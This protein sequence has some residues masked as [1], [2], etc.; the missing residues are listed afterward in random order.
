[1]PG[2]RTAHRRLGPLDRQELRRLRHDWE[3]T[4][5]EELISRHLAVRPADHGAWAELVRL[6]LQQ[7]REEEALAI[8]DRLIAAGTGGETP[9]AWRIACLDL[10]YRYDEA[11]EEA[12]RAG[13]LFPEARELPVALG[14]LH[15]SRYRDAEAAECLGRAATAGT[16]DA[17]AAAWELIALERLGRRADIQ[18]RALQAAAGHPDDPGLLALCA[19]VL[20]DAGCT[21]AERII[22]LADQALDLAPTHADA[23]AART[24]IL[25]L[26]ARWDEARESAEAAA[27]AR[28]YNVP[29]LAE[30]ADLAEAQG[31][32]ADAV[33]L[34]ERILARCEEVLARHPRCFDA[35]ASRSAVLLELERPEEAEDAARESA[36][37]CPDDPCRAGALAELLVKRDPEAA[38]AVCDRGL[39][40]VPDAHQLLGVRV[41]VLCEAARWDEAEAAARDLCARRPALATAWTRL[42]RLLFA[43]GRP[44]DALAAL[45]TA[46][47]Q[48]PL[49]AKALH[50][51]SLLLQCLERYEDAEET[52][53]R[54]MDADPYD[55][56]AIGRLADLLSAQ[57][58]DDEALEL[59]RRAAERRPYGLTQLVDLFDG[60]RYCD[61]DAEAQ[62]LIEDAL[63][64][65]PGS[66][67]LL[68]QPAYVFSDRKEYGAALAQAERALQADPKETQAHSVR[69]KSL[70][71][72]GR[73]QEADEAATRLVADQPRDEAALRAALRA[74]QNTGRHAQ[75]LDCADR[76]LALEPGNVH[77]LCERVDALCALGRW[78]EA[79]EAGR[80]ACAMW[81]TVSAVRL[82][83]AD[84][85]RGRGLAEEALGHTEA[86]LAR[87]PD[88]HGA[89]L[90][91]RRT[92]SDLRRWEEAETA[93]RD[94]VS[95]FPDSARCRLGLAE[96]LADVKRPEEAL[97][98]FLEA[99]RLAPDWDFARA[100]AADC[101]TGL[102]RWDEARALVRDGLRELPDAGVLHIQAGQ[103]AV[104]VGEYDEG[105]AALDE[106]VRVE[107]QYSWAHCRRI[108]VLNDLRRWEDADRAVRDALR[109]LP[110]DAGVHRQIALLHASRGEG[111]QRL[112]W[113]ERACTADPFEEE[114][115]LAR[116]TALRRLERWDEAAAAVRE[117]L[118]LHPDSVDLRVERAW[119][120]AQRNRDAEAL[121]CLDEALRLDPDDLWA[122]RSRAVVLRA[123]GRQEE[124]TRQARECLA[125]RPAWREAVSLLAV[126]LD[127]EHRFEEARVEWERAL[128]LAPY[129]TSPVV[130]LSGALRSLGCL[131]EAEE[132]VRAAWRRDPAELTLADELICVLVDLGRMEEAEGLARDLFAQARGAEERARC[133]GLLGWV[134]MGRERY[135]EAAVRYAEAQAVG[136]AADDARTV[137]ILRAWAL[138]RQGGEANEREADG[139][140]RAV[141][142]DA[143]GEEAGMAHAGRGM[144]AFRAGR[145]AEAE[146]HFRRAVAAAPY[147][148][149]RADLGAV[150]ASLARHDEARAELERAVELDPRSVHARIELGGVYLQQ[151][152][153]AG[154]PEEAA[155]DAARAAGEFRRAL[156]L[157]PGSARAALGLALALVKTSGAL[158]DAEDVLRAA[159]EHH[160][161]GAEGHQLRLALARLLVHSG[162]VTQRPLLYE[163]AVEEAA[164]AL[165]LRADD[166]EAS[167]VAGLAEQRLAADS[168]DVRLRALHRMRALAHFKRCRKLGGARQTEAGRALRVLEQE[169]AVARGGR[170]GSAVLVLVSVVVLAAV[171]GEFL[172]G[173]R[174]TPVMVSTLTPVFAGLIVL[175]FLLPL[176]IRVKLPGGLEAD[177]SASL[178]QIS[179]G[180]TG[181]VSPALLRFPTA[182][183]P[184]GQLPRM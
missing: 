128:R 62:A 156:S 154:L 34:R 129:D 148:A 1:M 166:P 31:R 53:R 9:H 172:W 12:E 58:K 176:L 95:R 114:S 29:L 104:A 13:R 15:L 91:H 143:S 8:C 51:R 127:A 131:D 163:D 18:E 3:F 158:G 41:D 167:F 118:R 28:P 139:L 86:V 117:A 105:V 87:S 108:A 6:R 140:C 80:R 92:L 173:D 137:Q 102:G 19:T 21:D 72:L 52:A 169:A 120:F 48:D 132:L 77:A 147:D 22:A 106:A 50:T 160:P 121:A 49:F 68:A 180:P 20:T 14:R 145:P 2:A 151:A 157:E 101:L 112:A 115:L 35:A 142:A 98:E 38:L 40:R 55:L 177:L 159:L 144:A 170:L 66:G 99:A 67:L 82:T 42:G 123:L 97:D 162:D 107:P 134:E 174:V 26:T 141:L 100:R 43:L 124:A 16:G 171:W 56:R 168:G 138:L 76:I 39:A 70:C 136:T 64:H 45:D 178:Q 88:H 11:H 181:E 24:R 84:A 30:A 71:E 135:A 75:A 90:G 122:L 59:Y 89:H 116:A 25:R 111:E 83:T 54:W 74:W 130:G 17:S 146:Q 37:R 125:R 184:V 85:L 27:R 103:L 33:A 57:D 94:A 119:Q 32:Q 10:L 113:A 61:R 60:L 155:Q 179:Q 164:E 183:G 149:W 69:L 81:P 109:E 73:A 65:R 7:G 4:A 78:D 182:S 96:V 5:A 63:R 175:G 44:D 79:V 93:A 36:A 153:G 47:E 152:D 150:L 110:D 161:D 23:L 165:R 126:A 46:L 133:L